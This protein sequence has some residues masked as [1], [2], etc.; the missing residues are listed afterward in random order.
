MIIWQSHQV[1]ESQ[2]L[3]N[4]QVAVWIL[5]DVLFYKYIVYDLYSLIITEDCAS[6]SCSQTI[7]AHFSEVPFAS[8]RQR[9]GDSDK[10][11]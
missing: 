10:N 4:L 11:T 3:Q 2:T 9:V 6:I 5:L 8:E 1:S 7:T